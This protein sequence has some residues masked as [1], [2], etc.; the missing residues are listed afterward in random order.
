[1]NKAMSSNFVKKYTNSLNKLV[2]Y[3]W[4]VYSGA[5]GTDLQF[6][7]VAGIVTWMFVSVLCVTVVP[8]FLEVGTKRRCEKQMNREQNALD[9]ERRQ[10]ERLR[11]RGYTAQQISY[12]QSQTSI[13]Q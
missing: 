1:M 10:V 3:T 4:Q 5:N 7:K 11:E 6:G 2:G 13:P 12:L 9:A 8:L